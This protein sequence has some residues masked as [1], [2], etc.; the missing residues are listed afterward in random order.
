METATLGETKLFIG[1]PQSHENLVIQ[2]C[3]FAGT[4]QLVAFIYLTKVNI[5]NQTR[6]RVMKGVSDLANHMGKL[7]T[8]INV[9]GGIEYIFGE[10][11]AHT[12]PPDGNNYYNLHA[13]AFYKDN[14]NII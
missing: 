3:T 10:I 13:R 9:R 11:S 12:T 7:H 6:K 5:S 4:G 1:F 14:T 2:D 8:S